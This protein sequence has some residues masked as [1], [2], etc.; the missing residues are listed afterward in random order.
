MTKILVV[1]DDEQ[2]QLALS[3]NLG[4][5][6]YEVV[7]CGNGR[8][9]LAAIE[10][11]SFD[12]VVSDQIMPEM[13]GLELLRAVE[14]RG[15]GVPVIMITAYG[16]ISQ[17]VEAMQH[18]AA[19]FIAKPFGGDELLRV[20]ERVLQ[21]SAKGA[22]K[23]K[24]KSGRARPI[25][26]GDPLMI[27]VLEIAEAVAR[28]DATVLIQGE[29]GTGKELIARLV[30]A[31]SPR[32]NN[33]F[34]A[35]NCA[36]LPETLLESEL[37]G[38]EKGA[39]TG[40]QQR[41]VG[42]FEL[43][44]GGTILLDEISEMDLPLQAKLLRVLQER[45]VDRVGGREPISID[46]RVLAT[47]NRN[48]EDMVKEGKF[49]GDLYYRLNV[50]PLVVPPLRKR[51]SD[52]KLLVEHFMRHNLGKDAP[53]LSPE[54]LSALEQYPWPGNVR[55]LQN[56]IERAA[57]LSQGGAPKSEDFMLAGLSVMSVPV[58]M[59]ST[60][61]HTS[62]VRE[63]R[64][65]EGLSAVHNERRSAY[66]GGVSCEHLSGEATVTSIK[67]PLSAQVDIQT[68]GTHKVD[69]QAVDFQ[70]TELRSTDNRSISTGSNSNLIV[71]VES[72]NLDSLLTPG[73]TVEEMERELIM[74]T[75]RATQ[76]NRTKAAEQL[77]ISTRTL[78]NKLHEYREKG[79][80]V[81]GE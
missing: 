71:E 3:A 79:L 18:G 23:Q 39:F 49:R 72:Q 57:I 17:A 16:T 59:E 9:G 21:L 70:T 29:S 67:A 61:A 5:A 60:I 12:L 80:A 6:G 48:L 34:V 64:S 50:I 52:I 10:S 2:M 77:G 63:D 56:S 53:K 37:F 65:T 41:K 28:S 4:R 68:V 20:I 14:E 13:S 15:L 51:R 30:H 44:H 36:A 33:S 26:T 35:V 75:L 31:S 66:S 69:N 19:D 62:R 78:R 11:G 27:K 38:H 42:K 8:E 58:Q 54:V 55:E 7:V 25:I 74:R 76:N 32:K 22:I 46:V 47:T 81:P 73:T 40:A 43:A 1:D 45:E 24:T